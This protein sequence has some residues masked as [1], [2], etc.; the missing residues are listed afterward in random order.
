M[1][2]ENRTRDQ[3]AFLTEQI[4]I[5]VATIAFGMGIDQSNVRYV[6]HAGMPKSLKNYQQESGR[7]DQDGV[8]AKC[9][10]FCS[11]RDLMSCQNIIA[12]RH[13]EARRS[14][15]MALECV[16]AY[17]TSVVY[18]HVNLACHCDK[19]G[20]VPRATRATFAPGSLK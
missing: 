10:L 4:E 9:W 8:E 17:C 7:A 5:T 20:I 6:I 16:A 12:N 3:A 18:H 13:D 11:M 19:C 15:E 1:T 14:A 2:D